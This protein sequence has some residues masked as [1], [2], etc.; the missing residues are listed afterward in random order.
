MKCKKVC[1]DGDSTTVQGHSAKDGL[2]GCVYSVSTS[3]LH[4]NFNLPELTKGWRIVISL[5]VA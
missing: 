4:V 3:Q 1:L 5:F 2:R